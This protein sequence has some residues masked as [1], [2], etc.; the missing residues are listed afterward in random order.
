MVV[1]FLNDYFIECI[2]I[3]D[4][5]L[6]DLFNCIST[7]GY[8][9]ESWAHGVLIP[10]HKNG[11]ISD[12]NNYRVITFVSCFSKLFTTRTVLNKRLEQLCNDDDVISEAQFGFRKGRPTVDA[13]FILNTKEQNNIKEN[14]R[15][16]VLYV[17]M[18]KCFESIYRSALWLKLYKCGIKGKLLQIVRDMYENVK[19]CVKSCSSLSEYFSYSVGLRQGEVM[20]PILFS[21]FLEDL[22]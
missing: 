17:D 9:P 3:I 16:H 19:S 22:P 11:S 21:L 15:L 5:H 12:V 2:D 4:G 10:L 20:S 1:T 7:S 14:E 18:L 8:F 13:I 6:C